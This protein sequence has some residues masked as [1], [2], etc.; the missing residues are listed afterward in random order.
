MDEMD[1]EELYSEPDD[2][3]L[4]QSSYGL[5]GGGQEPNHMIQLQNQLL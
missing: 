2:L 1:D 4:N 5:T 3:S